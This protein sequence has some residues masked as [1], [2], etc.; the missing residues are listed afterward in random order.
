MRRAF[1]FCSFLA[2][3]FG[4]A[5]AVRGAEDTDFFEKKVRPLLAEHCLECHGPEKHKGGLRWDSREGWQ[6]GGD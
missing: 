2:L 3:L 5:A 6:T 1:I 4:S